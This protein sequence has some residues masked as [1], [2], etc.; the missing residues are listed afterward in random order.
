MYATAAGTKII[1]ITTPANTLGN[2]FWGMQYAIRTEDCNRVYINNATIQS[3]H[4]KADTAHPIGKW[5][6]MVQGRDYDSIDISNN[7]IYNIANAI[8]VN[9][10]Y[11]TT[12]SP[13][14]NTSN[15][16]I[17]DKNKIWAN[18][19]SMSVN[20]NDYVGVAITLTSNITA[21]TAGIDKPVYCTNNNILFLV[22]AIGEPVVL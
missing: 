7:K 12:G 18:Y 1:D 4:S 10:F 3:N 9:N 21:S 13:I 14:A 5:G 16:I 19:G 22:L 15:S 11:N 8:K 17:I 20:N 2:A 6:I